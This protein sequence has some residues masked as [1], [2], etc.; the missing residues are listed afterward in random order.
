MSDAGPSR[1]SRTGERRS[2]LAACAAPDVPGGVPDGRLALL[3]V[4]SAGAANASRPPILKGPPPAGPGAKGEGRPSRGA[5]ASKR[6]GERFF[7]ETPAGMRRLVLLLYGLV[8]PPFLS[9]LAVAAE[10]TRRGPALGAVLAICGTAGG[11]ILFRRAPRQKDWIVP[12]GVAPTLCCGVAFVATGPSG[13]GF[14]T[15][16][17]APL[18]WAAVLCDAPVVVAAWLSGVVTCFAVQA[19][20][21]GALSGLE[22]TA[23]FAVIQGLVAWA[24]HGK[25]ARHREA[26]LRSVEKQLND[27]ELLVRR[28]GVI[29]DANDRAVDAY[30]HPRRVLLGMHVSELRPAGEKDEVERQMLAAE[31]HDGLVFEAEHVRQDGSRFPVEVS[32][33][34]YRLRGERYLHSVVRDISARRAAGAQ[35]LFVATLVAHMQEAVLVLDDA[36]R[37]KLWSPGAERMFGWSSEEAVQSSPFALFV[38]EE[39]AAE[40]ARGIVAAATGEERTLVARWRRKDGSEVTVSMSLVAMRDETGAISG[41]MGVARDVT[42]Q[43]AAEAA[44]R[45]SEQRLSMALVASDTEIWEWDLARGTVRTGPR[46]AE[47]LGALPGS[48][49]AA[50]DLEGMVEFVHPD[51]RAAAMAAVREHLEGRTDALVTEVRVARAEAST[52]YALVR[53]RVVARG[54]DGAPVRLLGTARDVTARRLAE[55]ER[56]RLLVEAR[57]ATQAREQLLAVVAHDLRN[58]LAAIAVTANG[59][60][61]AVDEPNAREDLVERREIIQGAA[62]RMGRLIEDLLDV[63]A[64]ENGGLRMSLSDQGAADIAREAV[65][66]AGPL[67]L[68]AG[69]SLSLEI[70]DPEAR[71]LCDPSRLAQVLSNLFSN[72]LHATPAGGAVTLRLAS[73]ARAVRFSVEDTGRG[74][75]DGQAERLFQPYERGT[76]AKYKGAGLGLAI[77]RGIVKGHAGCIWAE[78]RSGG[79]AAFHF[80]VPLHADPGDAPAAAR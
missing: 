26:R 67:A 28:D 27:I 73:E 45:E 43:Q 59:L 52:R 62:T 53:G 58:P 29:V 13:L 38:P 57:Q 21:R 36:F 17:A 22:N 24:V 51:D 69:V 10:P 20:A 71:V 31:E 70:R 42:A 5:R 1:A 60:D 54:P 61:R 23:V 11:W 12:V 48:A 72:A 34:A 2:D 15:V 47:L 63:A 76:G 64:I 41:V 65:R 56:Q 37:V 50:R 14:M 68:R 80:T 78:R 75:E 77:A 6:E 49:W 33:R 55:E 25:T 8:L 46:W 74:F 4:Q 44:L 30:G 35:R 32:A 66:A 40:I 7:E 18:A 39:G 19:L 9:I 79:G 3:T 16:L